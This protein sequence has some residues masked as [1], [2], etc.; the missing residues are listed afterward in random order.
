MLFIR[1]I[2]E[3]YPFLQGY[4]IGYSASFSKYANVSSS[5]TTGVSTFVVVGFG[6]SILGDAIGASS[7]V[8][9]TL[10]T[11]TVPNNTI[12]Y[13]GV[14]DENATAA[15]FACEFTYKTKPLTFK[16]GHGSGHL[17]IADESLGNDILTV[18]KTEVNINTKLSGQDTKKIIQEFSL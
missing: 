2:R 8:S 7:I 3:K 12:L 9:A 14:I 10:P 11:F 16:M 1:N 4:S 18:N 17:T 6:A 13:A 5:S 15:S